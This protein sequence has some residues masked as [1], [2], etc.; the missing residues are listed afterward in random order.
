MRVPPMDRRPPEHGYQQALGQPDPQI[1]PEVRLIAMGGHVSDLFEDRGERRLLEQVAA[2]DAVLMDSEP[3][4][5]PPERMVGDV[6]GAT[7]CPFSR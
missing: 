1:Q 2:R 7:N 3:G 6:V 4:R 5:E